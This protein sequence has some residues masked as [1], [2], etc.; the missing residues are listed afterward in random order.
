MR[1]LRATTHRLNNPSHR[2]TGASIIVSATLRPT[3][4][5]IGGYRITAVVSVDNGGTMFVHGYIV[6]TP[7]QKVVPTLFSDP[8]LAYQ[9]VYNVLTDEGTVPG[10]TEPI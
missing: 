6:L 10:P 1:R 8:D 5:G 7:Y 9:W 4:K 2:P 3:G